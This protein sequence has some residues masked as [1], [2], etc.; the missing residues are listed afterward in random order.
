MTT[1]SEVHIRAQADPKP[2]V[3]RHDTIMQCYEALLTWDLVRAWGATSQ[4]SASLEKHTTHEHGGDD[5]AAAEAL[6]PEDIVDRAI[7][8]TK[9]Y[10]RRCREEGWH[11]SVPTYE[12][13]EKLAVK[14]PATSFG[15]V[16]P[17]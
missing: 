3:F 1:V 8:T 9:A 12:E 13:A 7:T 5:S 15:F 17:E 14:D 6:T 11:L 2:Q 4:L 10:M 16:K